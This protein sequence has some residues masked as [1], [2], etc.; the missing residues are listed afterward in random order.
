MYL[1]WARQTELR[2]HARGVG[3]H[4]RGGEGQ[5]VLQIECSAARLGRQLE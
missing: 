2:A 1:Q 3:V 5:P 4:E